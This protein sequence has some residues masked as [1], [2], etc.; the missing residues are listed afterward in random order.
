[1]YTNELICNGNK[2]QLCSLFQT[3][4]LMEGDVAQCSPNM[5]KGLDWIPAW[6]K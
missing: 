4:C 2:V 1:M 5:H 3:E 6:G